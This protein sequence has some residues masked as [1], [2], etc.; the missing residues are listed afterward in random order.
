M[1]FGSIYFLYLPFMNAFDFSCRICLS[2]V[3]NIFYL[4]IKMLVYYNLKNTDK[5]QRT[6]KSPVIINPRDQNCAEFSN[7]ISTHN[8]YFLTNVY[9]YTHICYMA[10]CFTKTWNISFSHWLERTSHW[11]FPK[12][13]I[14]N[15]VI[16]CISQKLSPLRGS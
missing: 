6:W 1:H 5:Y 3:S 8:L 16:F 4:I 13:E 11:L 10:V 12:E 7:F 2:F 14:N 9:V 15:D